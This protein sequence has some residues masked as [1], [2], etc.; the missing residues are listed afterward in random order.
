MTTLEERRKERSCGTKTK[1]LTEKEAMKRAVDL[2]P[3]IGY[4]MTAY[5]CRFCGL[6]HLAREKRYESLGE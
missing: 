6:W 4:P 3:R 2:E 1:Y 5:Q